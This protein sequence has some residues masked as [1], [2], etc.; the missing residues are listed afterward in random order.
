EL[1]YRLPSVM[2]PVWQVFWLSAFSV[3]WNGIALVFVVLAIRSMVRGEFS[4]GLLLVALGFLATGIASI[5]YVVRQSLATSGVG[6]TRIE[7][8]DHPLKAGGK[9]N[10]FLSQAGGREIRSLDL[11][12][13]CDE[14]TT[15]R[16]G[17]DTRTE[18]RRVYS[19][20]VL[21]D[22]CIDVAK[23]QNFEARRE[24]NVPTGIMHSFK[25]DHNEIQWR[26]QVEG[27]VDRWRR[28][29]RS[30]PVMIHPSA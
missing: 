29:D 17:T 14:V 5:Y 19:Q 6:P 7:I 26:L 11:S 24:L 8:S 3:L 22:P 13:V 10:L 4:P 1:A 18:I 15:Y 28:Y 30:F 12:L 16:Q 20:S 2:K 21:A 23:G 25:A 27:E 9:Y